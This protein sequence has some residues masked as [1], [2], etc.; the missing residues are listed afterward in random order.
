MM[1][2]RCLYMG[3]LLLCCLSMTAQRGKTFVEKDVNGNPLEYEITSSNSV[4]LLG[5]YKRKY[6]DGVVVVPKN[7]RGYKVCEIREQ[8][9]FEGHYGKKKRLKEIL[10]PNT[11]TELPGKKA[12]KNNTYYPGVFDGC[13]ELRKI[14][15]PSNLK[16][17]GPSTFN[18][19]YSLEE[20]SIPQTVSEIGEACF[21]YCHNL[22]KIE[23]PYGVK[24]LLS[25]H[26]GMS[27]AGTFES[28]VNLETVILPNTIQR[29]DDECFALC[30][31]LT[32]IK[33]L[34]KGIQMGY[35]VFHYSSFPYKTYIES[36]EYALNSSIIQEIRSWQKKQEFETLA[37]YQSRVTK[38]NQK[39]KIQELTEEVIEEYTKKYK[40]KVELGD[41]NADHQLYA[42]NTNYGQKHVMVPLTEAPLFKS[43]FEQATFEASYTVTDEGLKVSE[44]T[45]NLNGKKYEAENTVVE[46][47]E[48]LIDIDL[49]EID[50]AVG[51]GANVSKPVFIID[52]AI[53][54]NIPANVV[55]NK[56][57]FAVIIGNERYQ[58]VSQVPYANNDA[59]IF[60]KYCKNTLGLPDKN[61]KLY[62]NATY[63]TMIGAVSDIQKIARAFKGDINVIFYYA[64]HGIPDEATGDGYLL[65][66]DA[67]GL[68]TEVCY[69]LNRLYKELG[70]L[71]AK[72]VVA[73][74]DA[75]FSGAQRG[76][77]M[78]VA[79]RGVAI[80]AK[81]DRPTG[82]TI[83][84]TAATDKQTAYPYTEK[85]HGMFTYYL[86]KKL[87][88]TKGDCTLG[89]LG[90]Y[91]CDEV[92]KQAVVTNGK[93]QT[94]VVLT[95]DG[96]QDSWQNLKLR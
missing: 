51:G 19:C 10:L 69:P 12:D 70:G 14:S 77:G 49:P 66:I 47:T 31:H 89:E 4:R 59:K 64:G 86:L 13:E 22:K 9:F 92:A 81:S 21:A 73:F 55:D 88:D 37:D 48:N 16:V 80:K 40:I 50:L 53:D 56:Q 74:L 36:F 11:I 78:V 43:N 44:L 29:I 60:A 58:K 39:K 27:S 45:V 42:L 6:S 94:P 83:V 72:S 15:L 38:E 96:V 35:N 95:S 33:G 76:D 8:A 23:I 32:T 46:V 67:D 91:I 2:Y 79:A 57:T 84:F 63:G 52:N 87:H 17:L 65:P 3:C 5:C 75:C 28:C 90:S 20:I 41:Y 93:E 85:G 26:A 18:G 1:F 68:N 30:S 54:Q 62:E 71:G 82:H 7:V 25:R 34:H 24:E 61:V